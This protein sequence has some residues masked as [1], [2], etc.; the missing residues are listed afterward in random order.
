MSNISPT[1]SAGPL[2]LTPRTLI[3]IVVLA[4]ALWYLRSQQPAE[5]PPPVE[6]A[7]NITAPS[8]PAPEHPVSKFPDLGPKEK[9]A[10]DQ[11]P[12]PRDRTNSHAPTSTESQDSRNESRSN[13]NESD[14]RTTIR[15][16]TIRDQD[17]DVVFRGDIDLA[18]T[19][20]RIDSGER[21]RFSND[22]STFQNR[23]GRLP[24]QPPGYYREW[25]HPTPKLSG[26]GPQRVVTGKER[27]AYCTPDHYRTFQRIR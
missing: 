25:V 9:P 26:P 1:R 8:A 5:G 3:V 12:A 24:R 13:R 4:A 27:E 21:L 16:A 10:R 6:P 19:L 23:E 20:K 15:N 18:P 17:G 22:G 7:P 11:R 2:P 14:P